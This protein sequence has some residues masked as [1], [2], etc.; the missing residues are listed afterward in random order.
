MTI[1]WGVGRT[2]YETG[3]GMNFYKYHVNLASTFH[4]AAN[5]KYWF[6]VQ[7]VVPVTNE[8]WGQLVATD[9]TYG[10]K[11]AYFSSGV[12]NLRNN[13]FHQ[14]KFFNHGMLF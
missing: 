11:G 3:F 5:T 13:D 2:V 9:P 1:Y 4:A 12:W 10:N 14:K 8:R 6:S 7:L